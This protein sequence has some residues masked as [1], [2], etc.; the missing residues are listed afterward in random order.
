MLCLI[1]TG[2]ADSESVSERDW[3]MGIGLPDRKILWGRAGNRCAFPDCRQELIRLGASASTVVGEEAHIVA[4]EVD[5]PRGADSM[6]EPERD[7]YYN[8]ILLCPT[9]HTIVDKSETDFTIDALLQMKSAHET[10]VATQ[11]G[12][13]GPN[14]N[15]IRYA[16]LIQGWQE[17]TIDSEWWQRLLP[18][19]FEARNMVRSSDLRA[20]EATYEWIVS[21]RLP[22]ELNFL[23]TEFKRFESILLALLSVLN[24]ILD[25]TERDND[26]L[27]WHRPSYKDS[28]DETAFETWDWVGRVTPDLALELT[29]SANA[30]C[31]AVISEF[32]GLFRSVEG[33]VTLRVADV[34][35]VKLYRPE[36]RPSDERFSDLES[37]LGDR[38]TRD[39]QIGNGLDERG[40]RRIGL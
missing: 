23:E 15:E 39:Y 6:P 29:R 36:Y 3:V 5:G 22:G 21:R 16:E 28:D 37:F 40:K 32:E 13:A 11:L 4:R 26:A 24:G 25:R 1:S 2:D 34:M 30:I 10:W 31:D 18:G 20:A 33:V 14:A 38:S 35:G 7:R 8:L 19:C 27:L 12:V 17:R 9:H